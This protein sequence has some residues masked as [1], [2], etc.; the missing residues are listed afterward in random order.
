MMTGVDLVH[1]P[2]RGAQPA[3]TDVISGQV[4]VIFAASTVEYIKSGKVRALAD[5]DA[6]GDPADVPAVSEFVP[7]YDA[8]CMDWCWRTQKHAAR[9]PN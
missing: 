7:G 3:L 8:G 4:Q 1:V 6:L 9:T 5:C 2:Y